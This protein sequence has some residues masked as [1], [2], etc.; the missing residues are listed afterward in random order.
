M[1][2]SVDF[3]SNLSSMRTYDN[4]ELVD[5]EGMDCQPIVGTIAELMMDQVEFANVI[6]LNK[7]DL[8][9]EGQQ[10]DLEEKIK[11]LNPKAKIVKSIQAKIDLN[12]II[13][14]GL[15]V[16]KDEFWVTS[17]QQEKAN[18]EARKEGKRVPEACTAR[19]DIKSFVYRA[20]KPFHPGRLNDLVVEPFF[21]DPFE[22]LE[23]E[24]EGEE[25][26][27]ERTEEEK[28]ELEKD[29]QIELQAVQE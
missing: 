25:E 6:I 2:D 26:E 17:M 19:F 7:K 10:N 8:V 4:C 14:T 20:R 16:N 1:I 15:Y 9:N 28:K 24:E 22:N 5:L 11:C 3:Y 12:E 18:D 21:M 27:V 13:N 29:K 23:E